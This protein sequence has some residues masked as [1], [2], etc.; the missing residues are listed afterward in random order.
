[1]VD[2]GHSTVIHHGDLVRL[3]AVEI[4]QLLLHCVGKNVDLRAVRVHVPPREL[5]ANEV[6]K[7]IRVV[8][9]VFGDLIQNLLLLDGTG[10]R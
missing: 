5:G 10:R 8:Q 2:V 4:G 6:G 1:M 3:V 9:R 7:I